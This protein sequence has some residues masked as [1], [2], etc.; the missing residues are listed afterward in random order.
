M[1]SITFFMHNVYAIGGTVKA[2]SQLANTLAEKG[3]HVEIISVFKAQ[4]SP[5]FELHPS[6]I[7]K[8]LI[9]YRP[10]PK[11]LISIFFNRIR[12]YTSMNQPKKISQFEPGI[13][14]FSR[15][16]ERKMIKALNNISTDVIVG[17]RASFNILIG[18]HV[19][20]HIE[21]IGMEHMN[22]SAHP[23]SYQHEIIQAYERLDK[24]TTLTSID[25][26]VYQRHLSR[27]VYV[28][29]NIL[30]EPRLSLSKSKL[31]TAA[32]RLEYEKGF[33]LLIQS[34]IP[35]KQHLNQFNYIVEIFG[36]GQE[37]DKLQRLIDE[38]GL[39][40][41][42][43]L[44][45]QTQQLN[46]Q[47]AKSEI[48]VI[49]S[50]NEGFG[51]VILEAMNQGSIIVS[52]DGNVGPDSIIENNINGYLIGHGDIKALS[53]LLLRL[54]NQELKEH[55]LIENGYK[56]VEQYSPDKVYESFIS[57]LNS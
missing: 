13:N 26:R 21:K 23:K 43:R 37:K 22:F 25:R 56:T 33:D 36:E 19:A 4:S 47:L 18:N 46:E 6:I 39:Q 9:D 49:P 3:H 15:Y 31:I 55:V 52:F 57:M 48:T 32:G 28:I 51:M 14:Q 45:G 35:I 1:K 27:P 38:N 2:I 50:R 11:N 30:S 7:V 5:Y 54:I 8:P 20:S 53:R 41:I 10:H 44:K 24:I 34:L 12:R 42:V 29:P 17:T 16:V 40:E